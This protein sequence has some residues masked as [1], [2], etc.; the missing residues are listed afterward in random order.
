M[1]ADHVAVSV[2]VSLVGI[3]HFCG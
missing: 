3:N 1:P 2:K